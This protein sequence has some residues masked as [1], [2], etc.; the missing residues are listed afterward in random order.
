MLLL[1]MPPY[2]LPSWR[3]IAQ[4]MWERGLLFLRRAGTV[5]LALSIVLWALM[6]Y[7][8]NEQAVDA[9]MAALRQSVGERIAAAKLMFSSMVRWSSNAS[10][11]GM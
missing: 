11:C 1:E 9:D 7:P 3:G 2:R 6:T 10:S 5:I 8:Q 4:R